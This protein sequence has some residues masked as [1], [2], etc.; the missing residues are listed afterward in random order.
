MNETVRCTKV[1]A[2]LFVC[3]SMISGMMVILP[4]GVVAAPPDGYIQG[5]VNDGTNPLPGSIVV[6]MPMF[7]GVEIIEWTDALGDYLIAAPGGLDYYVMAFNDSCY[8]ST[9]YVRVTSS[10]TVFF[11]FTLSNIA[12]AVTDVTLTGFVEDEL[13]NPVVDAMIGAYSADPATM[14]DGPPMYIN[15]TRTDG[16]GQYVVDVLPT[17]AGGGIVA[18]GVPGYPFTDNNT[19]E[20]F[21]SGQTYWINLTLTP[22]SYD[23]DASVSG[24]VTDYDTGLPLENVMVSVESW[25]ESAGE[26]MSNMTWTDSD[27]EYSMDIKSGWVRITMSKTGYTMFMRD[28]LDVLPGENEVVDAT[29]RASNAMVRGNVT[30]GGTG[31]PINMA[32]VFLF[33]QVNGFMNI[34]FTDVTGAYTLEAFDG[35][36]LI[37]GA[38]ADG[39]GQQYMMIDIDPADELWIDFEIRP[40]DATVSGTVTDALSGL[41]VE[42]AGIH[43][44]SMNYSNWDNSD[45][46]GGYDMELVSG[47]YT[48]EVYSPSHRYKTFDVTISPGPNV[49]DIQLMPW[50][51]PETVRLYGF[52][53]DSSTG[54]GIDSAS[55]DVGLGPPDYSERNWTWSDASGYYELMIPATQMIVVVSAWDHTHVDTVVDGTNETE[56]RADF[57]LDPDMWGPNITYSQTPT[58]N[59]SWTNPA[60]MHGEAQELDAR[61]LGLWQFM[62]NGSGSG[63]SYYY[64]IEA[65]YTNLHPLEQSGNNLPFSKVGDTYMVDQL[66]S[67]QP[68][69]GW[70][71]DGVSELFLPYYEIWMGPSMYSGLRGEYQNSSLMSPEQGTAWFDGV[72]GEFLFFTFDNGMFETAMPDDPTGVVTVYVQLIQV[73]DGTGTWWWMGTVPMGDWSVADLTF[74]PDWVAPSGEYASLFFVN[75]WSG[76]GAV[77]LTLYTVDTDPPVADAGPGQEAVVDTAVTLDGSMSSDNVGIETY[78]WSFD[79]G[80][81]VVLSGETV[82]YNFT[83]VGNHTVT[84]TVWDGAGNSDTD[85]TWVDVLGDERPVADAGPDQ[86]VAINTAVH[87]DGTGSSDDLGIVNYTWTIVELMEYMWG[88]TPE[89]TFTVPGVY[90]VTLVVEDTTGK[91]SLPDTMRVTAR[92]VTPPTADAGT[93]QTMMG[94]QPTFLDGSGSSDDVAIVNWTWTFE[95]MGSPVELYGEIVDFTFWVEGVYSIT[96]NVT[97]AA[98]NWDTDEVQVTIAGIIPEFPTIMLPVTGMLAVMLFAV[99][100]K[101]RL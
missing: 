70:L 19:D 38:E 45:A 26:G 75:D 100:R 16:S 39:Y 65:L 92:D 69:C 79:D 54:T 37:I 78:M 41:P 17:I 98:G 68:M 2:A 7:G 67:A 89:H 46:T 8:A 30:D 85:T 83:T 82:D 95:Y 56:I 23:N 43:Y 4:S 101:R 93:D 99:L 61:A 34:A 11:N 96:L 74:T 86:D 66:W 35:T 91:L 88:P 25:N 9:G 55:V 58:E 51:L 21:V 18:L 40:I 64:T 24:T 80:G 49:V 20:A 90:N 31:L 63:W 76:R 87:F 12:P 10:E 48:V 73:Q 3:M 71:S 81:L 50:D 52:V 22:L 6:A 44:M 62:K 1:L 13:G 42:D 47:D 27:G 28:S 84:L 77:N 36:D 94:G 60:W 53:N 32:R 97:D 57:L 59:V 5:N 33:D 14:G 72:T 29:L 15:M